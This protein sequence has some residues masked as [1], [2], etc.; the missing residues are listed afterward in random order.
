MRKS[1]RLAKLRRG[2]SLCSLLVVM[3]MHTF[4]ADHALAQTFTVLHTF[5][6]GPRDGNAGYGGVIR[7]HAGNLYGTTYSGGHGPGIIYKITASGKYSILHKFTWPEGAYSVAP[8]LLDRSGNLY[9]TAS[10]GGYS[11]YTGTVFEFRKRDSKLIPLH[12][13]T[14]VTDGATPYAGLIEDGDGNFYGTTMYGGS[15]DGTGTV[16][17]LDRATGT[18][19]ILYAFNAQP[20][21]S[22]PT[23]SVIRTADGTLYGTTES[24]G[25]FGYPGY[26]TVFKLDPSG[27]ETSLYAF[28]NEDDGSF[29]GGN[30]LRDSQGNLYGTTSSG[31]KFFNGTIYKLDPRGNLT[32]LHTFGQSSPDGS[33]PIESGLVRDSAGNFYGTTQYGGTIGGGTV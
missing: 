31:G 22:S 19:S 21:G 20:D 4:L 2:V 16:F 27:L 17:K 9:G 11:L 29:P 6:G 12:R 18:E 3:A 14:N 26:G 1:D 33:E 5:V 10:G 7:D 15:G 24:G 13:F 25:A 30:L 8:L 28:T 23:G 32:L